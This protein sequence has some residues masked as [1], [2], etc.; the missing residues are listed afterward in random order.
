MKI[1]IAPD[2]FK[3]SLTAQQA[4]AAMAEGIHAALP[5]A[6]SVLL[7]L[8]DGGEGTVAAMRGAVP[9]SKMISEYVVGP[10]AKPIAASYSLLSPD[11]TTAVIE[12]AQATRLT[13]VPLPSEIP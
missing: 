10:L 5:D 9:G 4:A 13:L 12:M 6:E 3:G 8:A 11:Y 2:L 1:I 7:P